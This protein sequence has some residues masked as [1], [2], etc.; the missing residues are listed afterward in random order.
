MLQPTIHPEKAKSV[1]CISHPQHA[2]LFRAISQA[3]QSYPEGGL[4][5]TIQARW[6]SRGPEPEQAGRKYCHLEETSKPPVNE[7]RWVFCPM[8]P[9]LL[10]TSLRNCN[11]TTK[12]CETTERSTRQCGCP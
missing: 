10:Q 7:S 5:P 9:A 3:A 1:P 2:S 12:S 4:H 11:E 6:I 8:R